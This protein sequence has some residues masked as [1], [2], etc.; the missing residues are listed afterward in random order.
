M[1]WKNFERDVETLKLFLWKCKN[2][3]IEKKNS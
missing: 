2:L 1:M 3:K